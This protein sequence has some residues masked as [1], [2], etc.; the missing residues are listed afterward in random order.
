MAKCIICRINKGIYLYGIKGTYI[1]DECLSTMNETKK[2]SPD[3]FK[4]R[5]KHTGEVK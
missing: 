3:A 5:N 1:C 4:T 2:S